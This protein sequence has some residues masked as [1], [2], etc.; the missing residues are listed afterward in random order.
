[1]KLITKFV[2][3]D[4]SNGSLL[5][6]RPPPG[7]MNPRET[8]TTHDSKRAYFLVGLL[9]FSILP[10][11][12][13]GVTADGA[14]DATITIQ[15]MPANGLEVN[16]GESGE[17]TVRVYN[18]GPEAI[19]LTLSTSEEATTECGS[20]SSTIQPISEAVESNDYGETTMSVSLTQNAEGS[21]D[22]TI[23][24]TANEVPPAAGTPA[25][26][27]KIVT[28]T[29]G[30]GSGS[31]VF[32]VNL[33]MQS[34]SQRHQELEVGDTLIEYNVV[35]ENTGQTNETIALSLAEADGSG[36][37]DAGDLT[38]ELDEETVTLDQNETETVTVSVEVPVGQQA[39]KYCWELTGTVTNDVTQEA[40]DVEEFDLTVPELKECSME[41]SKTSMTVDPDGEGT[42]TTTLTNIGNSDWSVTMAKTGSRSG[43]VDYDGASSGLLPYDDGEGTK[44]FDIIVT[45]DDSVTAG[46]E[47]VIQIIAKDGNT[48]KCSKDLRV[49]VGQS[50]GAG[51]S[52]SS[53]TLSNI[54]PGSNG[55]ATLTV[56]NQG[57]G[58]DNLRISSSAPPS[59]WSVQLDTTTVSVGSKHGPDKSE[60]I[61]I[62][63][64]VPANA[65]ATEQIEITFSVLP[66]GGGVA[67]AEVM[68]SVSVEAIH[69]IEVQATALEQTGRSGVL[70]KF[71]V[72][73]QNTG[74]TEDHYRCIESDQ[75]ASP[76]WA[77]HCEDSNGN[78]ISSTQGIL[79]APQSSKQVFMAVSID[80]AEELSFSR[81]TV[82]IINKDDF[83][84]SADE[85]ND[86]V[87]DNQRQ[88]DVM[89]ILS[90]RVFAMDVRLVDGGLDQRSGNSLLP[91]SGSQTY[92]FWVN[93]TGDGNDRA[94][95]DVSGLEG[96]ATRAITLYGLPIEGEIQI[97]VGFG[98]WDKN[99]SVFLIDASGEPIIGAS[100]DAAED[101]MWNLGHS[102]GDYEARPFELYFEIELIVNPGAETGEGGILELV[103]T[104]TKNAADRSGHFDITL[105]VQ[106][107]Y[108]F[109]FDQNLGDTEIDIIYPNKE[110]FVINLTNTG[111]IDAEVIVF[112]SE[113]FRGWSVILSEVEETD[114]CQVD[115]NDFI[116]E[117]EVGQT[118]GIEV[119]IR[120]PTGAEVA[121]TYKFTLSAEPVETGV[122]DRE[123]IEFTVNGDV[124]PGLLGLGLSN[125]QI[126]SGFFILLIIPMLGIFFNSGVPAVKNT[127]RTNR[128]E[129]KIA[130]LNQLIADGHKGLSAATLKVQNP[131]PFRS[132]LHQFTLIPAT[133]GLYSIY[134][135]H[136]HSVEMK[137]HANIGKGGFKIW[138]L[139]FIF[140]FAFILPF[141]LLVRSFRL[142]R[143]TMQLETQ[144]GHKTKL[145]LGFIM[146][147]SLL[148]MVFGGVVLVTTLVIPDLGSLEFIKSLATAAAFIYPQF[149]IWKAF[150]DSLNISWTLFFT[151]D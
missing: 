49:I 46:D 87:P 60:S 12:T 88:F 2:L 51:L 77:V 70:V 144:T 80:G 131:V 82:L 83:S 8:N 36:C 115:I 34:E 74:N 23:T 86:G 35:V 45:P 38:V 52:L 112:S 104:S 75:T 96:L 103:V 16:P 89:A 20:Y 105:D 28:T 146:I 27:T 108:E 142:L 73:I 128:K 31:A 79:I 109:K 32:G 29:A 137:Q 85:N 150:Q 116:C 22:T 5:I 66:A 117:V 97:P 84:H 21:C 100:K 58:L 118:I 127:I 19:T 15:T 67:Y 148:G 50:F 78:L 14:R 17:Y 91:P 62:V 98:I 37:Q 10:M 54:E 136:Q 30:D 149:I 126:Q 76:N 111:N 139:V 132:P 61:G 25:T 9:L 42:L 119:S 138:Q 99:N 71:P 120:S 6:V 57:N 1:M 48:V 124:D 40:S 65:L 101:Q 145:S 39:N 69:G 26:E 64:N 59:G 114:T 18:Q 4:T 129:N 44:T 13:A 107:L 125:S 123:N 143:N 47:S 72:T 135:I 81:V 43:W 140:P 151:K 92:G 130:L 93:N 33:E 134:L 94:V 90:D 24:V 55:T 53:T 122:V 68:L 3:V 11:F 56:T 102:A 141:W 106:I 113:S 41:L 7:V 121:D 95:F 133:F 63:V 147:W 110:V